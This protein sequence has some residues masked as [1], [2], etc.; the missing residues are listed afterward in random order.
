VLQSL[1]NGSVDAASLVTHR[2]RL[3]DAAEA[4][5][6]LDADPSSALQVV[7]DFS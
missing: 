2:Y 3:D 4:Y 1:A 6:M 7:L 5:R